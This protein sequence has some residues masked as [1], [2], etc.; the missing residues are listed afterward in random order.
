M[1]FIVGF[2]T[3]RRKV[4]L[5]FGRPADIRGLMRWRTPASAPEE[6]PVRDA[7]EF[8]KLAT[9][10][11]RYYRKGNEAA[12]SLNDLSRRIQANS[13][14]EVGFLLLAKAPWHPAAPVLTDHFFVPGP[15]LEHCR[16]QYQQMAG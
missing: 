16:R 9:K 14:A 2:K 6:A 5:D 8:R 4:H 11:W 10:R 12:T 7:M 15:T 3:Q 13:F 1:R